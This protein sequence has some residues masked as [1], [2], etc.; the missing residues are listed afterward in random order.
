MTR[1]H[2]VTEETLEKALADADE[3]DRDLDAIRE[4]YVTPEEA[5]GQVF[6][7]TLHWG[8]TFYEAVDVDH[9]EEELV[10][11]ELFTGREFREAFGEILQ[12]PFIGAEFDVSWVEA[13]VDGEWERVSEYATPGE[14]RKPG[15][16]NGEDYDQTRVIEKT[17]RHGDDQFDAWP[18]RID[19]QTGEPEVVIDLEDVQNKTVLERMLD[20]IELPDS[21]ALGG[22]EVGTVYTEQHLVETDD[23]HAKEYE[24]VWWS[25]KSQFEPSRARRVSPVKSLERR[26][27]V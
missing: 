1:K 17:Y 7:K 5:V 9:E 18:I 11:E 23:G 3:N 14:W 21:F 25:V 2:L 10:L 8:W 22:L 26:A 24:V 13:K 27:S 12:V 19:H 15:L 20:S 16:P 4:M 6:K